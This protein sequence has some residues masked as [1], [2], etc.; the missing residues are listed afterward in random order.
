[1]KS[2]TMNGDSEEITIISNGVKVEGK[3]S[4]DGS[5]RLDGTIQGD[6]NCQGNVSIGEQGE[7]F[8]KVD[9]KIITIGGK[10]EGM[11]NAKEKLILESKADLKGDVFTKILVV[12]AGARFDGKSNMGQSTGSSASTPSTS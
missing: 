10:V 2:K 1:M 9:G 6:I 8:G 5:I 7:V 11:I 3:V 4:S 12:E